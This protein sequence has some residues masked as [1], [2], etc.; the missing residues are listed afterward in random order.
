MK[1]L[2]G[3]A[4]LVALMISSG[5]IGQCDEN[6]EPALLAKAESEE[7][8]ISNVANAHEKI[9]SSIENQSIKDRYSDNGHS[10]DQQTRRSGAVDSSD[11]S[12]DISR[13]IKQELNL[14]KNLE[15]QYKSPKL[16]PEQMPLVMS[17][18]NTKTKGAVFPPFLYLKKQF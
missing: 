15:L 18:K 17:S 7:L 8:S 1:S 16:K 13:L 6:G 4:V 2:I 11:G 12:R 5:A 10:S 14:E 3:I 9:K